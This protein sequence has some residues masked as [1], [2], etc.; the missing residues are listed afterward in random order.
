MPSLPPP[1]RCAL[2]TDKTESPWHETNLFSTKDEGPIV[3]KQLHKY[4][5]QEDVDALRDQ[6]ALIANTFDPEKRHPNLLLYH[7]QSP[8]Q[9][10]QKVAMLRQFVCHNLTEKIRWMPQ[11]LA[12]IEKQWLVFQLLQ[13]CAQVHAEHQVHGDIKPENLLVTST[14]WLLLADMHPYKQTYLRDD[15]LKL[16]N[17]YFGDMDNNQRCYIAPERW[18]SPGQPVNEKAKLTPAMDIFSAGCVIAEILMDGQ[19]L[20]DLAKLQQYRHGTQ[21]P[22]DE[23]SKR[24]DDPTLVELVLQMIHRDPAQRPSAVECIRQW[25]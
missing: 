15:D 10:D 7:Q 11:L 6:M 16:S 20:F 22:N 18:R 2:R 9:I 5:E 12:P 23:L 24:I 13:A 25:N 1:H 17:M 14:S 8:A 3:V 21:N 19:P 4:T